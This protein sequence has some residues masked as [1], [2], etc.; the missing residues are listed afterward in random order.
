MQNAGSMPLCQGTL[1]K[2]L[3]SLAGSHHICGSVKKCTL[4]VSMQ[5]VQKSM[6][7][8]VLGKGLLRK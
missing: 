1:A 8:K 5:I 4:E 2:E 3:F 7:N 6:G